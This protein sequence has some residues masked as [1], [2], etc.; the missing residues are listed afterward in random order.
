M[1]VYALVYTVIFGLFPN[2][3][4]LAL[5]TKVSLRIGVIYCHIFYGTLRYVE[6]RNIWAFQRVGRQET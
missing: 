3:T 5:S 1:Y 6:V 2:Y 4:R